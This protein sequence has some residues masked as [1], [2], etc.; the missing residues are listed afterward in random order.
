V[1]LQ[2]HGAGTDQVKGICLGAFPGDQVARFEPLVAG[3]RNERLNV[4][5]AQIR[6]E[7]M[8]PEYG[9]ERLCNQRTPPM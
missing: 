1:N 7:W 2:R 6:E 9:F 3:A 5:R 8:I 4:L